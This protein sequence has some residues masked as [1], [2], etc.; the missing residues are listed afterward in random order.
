M[1]RYRLL[2]IANETLESDRL[3]DLIRRRTVFQRCEVTI[4]A[5]A[6]E[7]TERLEH[8]LDRLA[9]NGVRV[10]GWLEPADP[11]LAIEDALRIDPADE[12]IVA[13][14]PSEEWSSAVKRARAAF[15]IP[16]THIAVEPA[17]QRE[18]LAA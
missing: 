17:R 11:L 18:A 1:N 10:S 7:A 13:T 6:A 16:L 5:P 9:A 8:A 3:H 2:V 4:V 15:D 14:G 12:M